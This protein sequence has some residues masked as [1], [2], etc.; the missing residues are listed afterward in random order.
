M[1]ETTG[2][3]GRRRA[4]QRDQVVVVGQAARDLVL[5]VNRSPSTGNTASVRERIERFG[6]KG[7]NIAVG[8]QQLNPGMMPTLVAVLGADA[9]GEQMYRQAVQSALD[10]RHIARRGRT[11]LLVDV[12]TGG[13]ERQLL[14]DVTDESLVTLDDVTHAA[15]ALASAGIVVLQLQQPSNVLV[16]AAQIAVAGGARVVLDGATQGEHRDELLALATVVRADAVEASLLTGRT[17][18]TQSDAAHAASDLLVHRVQLVAL[19]V[20]GEGDLVAWRDGQQFHPHAPGG[21]VDSTGAG[22]AFVAGLVTGLRRGLPPQ[23][24]G[25]L[26]A[27]AAAATVQHLGGRPDL[28]NM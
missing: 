17:L 6:G 28:T 21:I 11:T 23:D 7:A 10:T 12:V 8:I 15:G 1:N 4:V 24:V 20:A 13:G 14:E 5:R 26:A 27:D 9:V 16:E 19:S 3:E 18:Q 22:D 25:H 2:R